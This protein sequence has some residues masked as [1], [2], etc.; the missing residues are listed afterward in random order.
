VFVFTLPLLFDDSLDSLM[1]GEGRPLHS[2]STALMTADDTIDTLGALQ[3]CDGES[4]RDVGE[5]RERA[6]GEEVD[7][8]W[9]IVYS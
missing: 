1:G 9:T 5:K 8:I 6:G 7:L 4:S 3:D 2:M